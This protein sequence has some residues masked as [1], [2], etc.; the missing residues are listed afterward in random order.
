[1]STALHILF[2]RKLLKMSDNTEQLNQFR[3]IQ[4]QQRV[5]VSLYIVN[6]YEKFQ[7]IQNQLFDEFLASQTQLLYQLYISVEEFYMSLEEFQ[8]YQ[9]N[10]FDQ[11]Q[12]VQKNE[13]DQFY[14]MQNEELK[15]F[16]KDIM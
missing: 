1:M 8:M 10:E 16:Q 5:C 9:K 2:F 3:D 12:M 4:T 11:F 6:Q 15:E 14:M 7:I 13:F